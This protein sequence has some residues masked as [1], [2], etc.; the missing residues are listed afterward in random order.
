MRNSLENESPI[1]VIITNKKADG[2]LFQNLLSLVPIKNKSNNYLY[3]VGV[4]IELILDELNIVDIQNVIDLV[5]IINCNVD[6]V[7]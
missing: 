6:S 5:S 7:K 3:V 1:S 2:T 4:Q